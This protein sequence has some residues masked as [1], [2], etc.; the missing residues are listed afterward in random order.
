MFSNDGKSIAYVS[1]PEGILWKANRDGSNP[2]QLTDPPIQVLEPRWSPD[3]TQIV[4]E[5]ISSFSSL[6]RSTGYIVSSEG[7][8]PQKILAEEAGYNIDSPNWS[9]DGHKIDE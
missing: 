7:G 8:S 6:D 9:P 2:V 3:G 5:D 1:Y 4:F